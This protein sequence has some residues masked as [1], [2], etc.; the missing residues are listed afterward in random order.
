[1]FL[2]QDEFEKL[3]RSGNLL[4]SGIYEGNHYGT[5]KPPHQEIGG[6]DSFPVSQMIFK[7][8]QSLPANLRRN[9][10]DKESLR[11]NHYNGD[12]AVGSLGPLPP[13]W[14]IAFSEGNEKYFIE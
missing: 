8:P 12:E 5:P 13:N 1:M 10:S 6:R 4:E 3:E 2:S 14:E 9:G 7:H 11:R